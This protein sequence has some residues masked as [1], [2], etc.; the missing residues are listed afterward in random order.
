M[1]AR[2][3]RTGRP[4]LADRLTSQV[5]AGE[6]PVVGTEVVVTTDDLVVAKAVA[7]NLAKAL[8]PTRLFGRVLHT[9]AH[10]DHY[11]VMVED[12]GPDYRAVN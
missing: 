5:A 12:R 6:R 4:T 2:I 1:S 7:P 11:H 3:E 9:E 8:H 10:D